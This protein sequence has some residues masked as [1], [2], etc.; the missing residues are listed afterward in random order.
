MAKLPVQCS[1]VL[2]LG[3]ALVLVQPS[4]LC[5]QRR[6]Q[7]GLRLGS[8]TAAQLLQLESV[9]KELKLTD[10]QK[11]KAAAINES[12]ISA[13]RQL[14]ANTAKDSNERGPKVAELNKNTD[15]DLKKTLDEGQWKRLREIVLQVN[16]GAELDKEDVQ[17][18]LKINDEQKTKLADIRKQNAAARREAL[19]QLQGEARAT[20]E[21]ELYREGNKK[22]LEVLSPEQKKQFEDMQ[23]AKFKLDLTQPAASG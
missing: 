14:F 20:K 22:L 16:D 10:E 12:V 19:A 15:N 21:A 13:R 9:Q 5:A 23:G 8:A 18:A 2:I 3:I 17:Q 7:G 1:N 11:G 4:Q 6:G